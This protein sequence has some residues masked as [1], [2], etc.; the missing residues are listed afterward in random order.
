M[1]GFLLLQANIN[2]VRTIEK[3][4]P[5][6]GFKIPFEI[7]LDENNRWVKLAQAIPW[8]DLANG[9]YSSFHD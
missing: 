5:L 6:S 1:H 7:P 2:I 3:Q 8:D 9:Y 4:L